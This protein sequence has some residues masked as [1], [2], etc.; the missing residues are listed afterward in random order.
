MKHQATSVEALLPGVSPQARAVV[1]SLVVPDPAQRAAPASALEEAWFDEVRPLLEAPCLRAPAA[2]T[3]TVDCASALLSREAP[4][5]GPIA[6]TLPTRAA[7]ESWRAA[8]YRGATTTPLSDRA[9][10]RQLYDE[11]VSARPQLADE[12]DGTGNS[13]TFLGCT[14]LASIV[15]LEEET[16]FHMIGHRRYDAAR[17][18]LLVHGPDLNVATSYDVL[19]ALLVASYAQLTRGA[20]RTLLQ[21]TYF[22]LLATRYGADVVALTCL[23]LACSFAGESIAQH[24]LIVER[25]SRDELATAT[26]EFGVALRRLWV[27]GAPAGHGTLSTARL[28]QTQR[29]ACSRGGVDLDEVL[30]RTPALAALL[31]LR[32]PEKDA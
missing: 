30:T 15:T 23:V 7:I 24:D 9:L 14:Y 29:L 1:L 11:L 10:A 17:E 13:Y 18:A 19:E 27:G 26:E 6:A 12:H 4:A 8:T 5:S 28:L 32:V 2:A 20:A 3:A 16:V 22:T 31:D 25:V 21:A